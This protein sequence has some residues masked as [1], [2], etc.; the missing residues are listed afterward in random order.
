MKHRYDPD[1]HHR[2]SIRLRGYDYTQAGAYYVTIV[3]RD[4]RTL[5]GDVIDGEMRLN[6]TG[7]LIID[8]WEWLGTRYR[9]V[10]LDAYVV[11]PNHLHG[12]IVITDDGKGGS[13]VSPA[14]RKSLGR[15]IGAF[16]TV[17]ARQVNRAL[18]MPGQRLWQRNYYEH[19]IRNDEECDRVREY[20]F[21]NP[22]RW[23]TDTENPNA[24]HIHHPVGAVREPP[25][26]EPL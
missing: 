18:D 7:Q 14:S 4:R 23:E 26:Q 11:M 12:I 24:V 20:I 22:M 13:S 21:C 15:L 8:A 5:F 1:H 10:E 16:K 3:T 25:L 19:V 9:Y 6:D 2:R 17:S